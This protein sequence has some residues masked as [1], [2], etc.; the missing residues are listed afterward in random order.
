MDQE[1]IELYNENAVW[2]QIDP[3]WLPHWT[4]L[5]RR[6]ILAR[7]TH[8]KDEKVSENEVVRGM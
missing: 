7:I 4:V 5:S 8:E 3:N 6:E 2:P 1:F